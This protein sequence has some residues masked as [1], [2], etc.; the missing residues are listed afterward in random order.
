MQFPNNE[1]TSLTESIMWELTMEQKYS[2]GK[3]NAA[4]SALHDLITEMLALSPEPTPDK[5][6]K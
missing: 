6:T 4:Y 1:A 2:T 3:Y 5:E